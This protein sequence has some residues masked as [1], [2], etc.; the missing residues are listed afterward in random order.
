MKQKIFQK[1][2]G[3]CKLVFVLQ[4]SVIVRRFHIYMYIFEHFETAKFQWHYIT[5]WIVEVLSL[6]KHLPTNETFIVDQ[7]IRHSFCTV[8]S[9]NF[10]HLRSFNTA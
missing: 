2:G 1:I 10:A 9:G 6:C 5:L 3:C 4:N 7:M 8:Q